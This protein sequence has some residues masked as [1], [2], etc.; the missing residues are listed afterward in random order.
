M[1]R[2]LLVGVRVANDLRLVPSAAENLQ[3]LRQTFAQIAGG[4][5][6]RRPLQGTPDER[7]GCS[8]VGLGG[9]RV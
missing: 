6:E 1:M 4:H 5:R 7:H 3:P 2:R 8:V 9:R